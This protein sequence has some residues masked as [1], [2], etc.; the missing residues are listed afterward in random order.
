WPVQV[1]YDSL[2]CLVL[3]T[4]VMLL[5]V[6][7]NLPA[8]FKGELPLADR[9]AELGA[10]ADGSE[11]YAAARPE[12]YYLFLFQLLKYFPGSSEIIGAIVIPTIVV[13]LLFLLPLAGWGNLGHRISRVFIV[14]LIAAAGVLTSMA[15]FDDYY[16]WLAPHLG[17]KDEKK[18]VASREFLDAKVAAEPDAE[19]TI[20]LINRR[21][22][23]PDGTLSEVRLIPKEGA[24]TLLRN[25]P[26]TRGS[27]LFA[28]HCASCHRY[29]DQHLEAAVQGITDNS[30]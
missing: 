17:L 12:W 25:D 15:L 11:P 22:T 8:L 13:V 21:E 6:H 4:I 9:G 16:A 30:T 27:R 5:V 23:R 7:F 24:V 1:M 29:L 19:R 18:L 14:V 10:P 3:L 26:E 20:E 28:Q 2:A